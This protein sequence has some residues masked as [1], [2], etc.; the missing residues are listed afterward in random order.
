MHAEKIEPLLEFFR[1]R[2]SSKG[3]PAGVLRFDH[4]LGGIRLKRLSGLMMQLPGGR[5]AQHQ[6]GRAAQQYIR[7]VRDRIAKE[8]AL[9]F[10]M[11]NSVLPRDDHR[12]SSLSFH[13]TAD[14]PR[15]EKVPT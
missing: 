10:E 4:D 3:G 15:Q 13:T 5:V 9:L 8:D 2:N 7:F 11:S 1:L 14:E 12:P 6:F